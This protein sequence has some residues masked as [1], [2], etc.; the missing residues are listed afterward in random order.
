MVF[1]SAALKTNVH[2]YDVAEGW[3]QL[4][5]YRQG[6]VAGIPWLSSSGGRVEPYFS[7]SRIGTR[8][9]PAGLRSLGVAAAEA[10]CQRGEP[11][12]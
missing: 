5:S 10:G 8:F 1:V 7:P 6:I 4:S 12:S 9:C 11:S 3:V 2:E